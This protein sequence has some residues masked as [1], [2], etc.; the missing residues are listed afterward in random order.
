MGT[1]DLF[2]LRRC[3]PVTA[4]AS[5]VLDL[6]PKRTTIQQS[7]PGGQDL[8]VLPPSGDGAGLA[9]REWGSHEIVGER[10]GREWLQ[11]LGA[12]PAGRR[13]QLGRQRGGGRRL[14]GGDV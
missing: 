13:G 14:F 5:R 10:G 1:L 6:L 11:A 12:V 8:W 2:G 4:K 9:G 3:S 7:V